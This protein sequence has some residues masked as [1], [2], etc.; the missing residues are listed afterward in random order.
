MH[1]IGHTYVI[2]TMLKHS[3]SDI[4]GLKFNSSGFA[5]GVC[6]VKYNSER[7]IHNTDTGLNCTRVNGWVCSPY[8]S[9][10]GREYRIVKKNMKK[11][12]LKKKV[13]ECTL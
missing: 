3:I 13:R 8:T 5:I 10:G 4:I 9:I 12:F 7:S 1:N 6:V 2:L 11:F